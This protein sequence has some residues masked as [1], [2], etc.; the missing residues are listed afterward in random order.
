[1]ETALQTCLTMIKDRGYTLVDDRLIFETD[2]NNIVLAHTEFED[3]VGIFQFTEPKFTIVCVHYLI[4]CIKNMSLDRAIVI[5]SDSIT[6]V[7]KSTLLSYTEH[8]IELFTVSELQYNVTKHFFVPIHIK[9]SKDESKDFKTKY[10]TK[11]A[12]LM[13]SCPVARYYYCK[14]GDVVKII[15][16]N[17]QIA[18]RIVR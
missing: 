13:K 15:R 17:G 2:D 18:Y 3:L 7:A 1:M 6:P 10:G 11:F 9:L 4:Q 12:T 5:Y 8:V 16:K 14:V